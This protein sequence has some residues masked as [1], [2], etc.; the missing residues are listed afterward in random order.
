MGNFYFQCLAH[1]YQYR[2]RRLAHSAGLLECRKGARFIGMESV[3][4]NTFSIR[5]ALDDDWRAAID[6]RG[7]AG[8]RRG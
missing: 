3:Y 1:D 7:V 8:D 5:S 4:Q 2:R 6:G